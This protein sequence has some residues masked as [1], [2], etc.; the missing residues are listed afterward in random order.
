MWIYTVRPHICMGV[1]PIHVIMHIAR[2]SLFR[3]TRDGIDASHMSYAGLAQAIL[4]DC[5]TFVFGQAVM[6]TLR[7]RFGFEVPT[8]DEHL[9][10]P[11]ESARRMMHSWLRGAGGT[12]A[13]QGVD[14]TP[15]DTGK[16]GEVFLPA[17]ARPRF[18]RHTFSPGRSGERVFDAWFQ[19][20]DGGWAA[21]QA[22]DFATPVFSNVRAQQAFH[23]G[24]PSHR[25][26]LPDHSRAE[27]S[28]PRAVR[29]RRVAVVA[30]C[31]KHGGFAD[32]RGAGNRAV[33]ARVHAAVRSSGEAHRHASTLVFAAR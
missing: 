19:E 29:P 30:A 23:H 20:G 13:S 6:H 7:T 1:P 17:D 3:A 31:A 2:A 11:R 21:V 25:H 15:V 26:P 22:V 9:A 10:H 24:Q 33:H 27:R 28:L 12:S 8:F 5:A 14:F 4:P 16:G 18:R 32:G